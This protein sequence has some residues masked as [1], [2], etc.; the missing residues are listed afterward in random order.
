[1]GAPLIKAV[2]MSTDTT[3]SKILT[4]VLGVVAEDERYIIS[5]RTI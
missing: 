5:S 3:Q 1:M 4:M 2:S